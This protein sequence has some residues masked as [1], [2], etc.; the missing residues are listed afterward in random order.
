[1]MTTVRTILVIAVS[2]SWPLYQMDVKNAFLHEDHQEEV[3][4]RLPQGYD[5]TSKNEVARLRRSL[6]GLKQSPRAW[7]E[8]FRSTLLH[9]GFA[10]SPYDPSL[11]L[12]N[13]AQPT[14]ILLVYVDDIIIT[15]THSKM[16]HSLQ[17]SLQTAFHMKDLGPL[18]YFLGL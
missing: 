18:T 9:H 7:F 13:T 1:M 4:M 17:S 15:G 12:N 10:Q 16:I 5:T 3:Y 11:F 14:T 2:C 8:K 6:C